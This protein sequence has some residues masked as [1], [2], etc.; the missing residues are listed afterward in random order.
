MG[1]SI[2]YVQHIQVAIL[3]HFHHARSQRQ[4][5]GRILEQ[6]ISRYFHFVIVDARYAMIQTDRI[7]VGNKMHLVAA[8]C[9]LEPQL[10]GNNAAAPVSGIA[11]DADLHAVLDSSCLSDDSSGY[12]ESSVGGH[13]VQPPGV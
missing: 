13:T 7:R 11:S 3:G 9:E 5:V 12:E 6:R 8:V 10:G 1:N 2:M 4:A